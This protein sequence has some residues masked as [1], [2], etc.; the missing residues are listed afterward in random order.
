MDKLKKDN[1]CK[2]CLISTVK[3]NIRSF[4]KGQFAYLQ[5]RGF[6]FTVISNEPTRDGMEL[7]EDTNYISIPITR[8]ITPITDLKSIFKL[9]RIFRREKFDLVQYTTPKG[10]ILGS[11]AAFIAK[12]PIR[13]YLMWGI[14]YVGQNGVKR[15]LFKF[16]DSMACRLSTHIT[17]DGFGIR[18]FAIE[19]QLCTEENSSVVGRGG[20]NGIDLSIFDPEKW[21]EEGNGIRE[22][23]GIPSN[24]VVIGTVMRMVGDKGIN[25]LV[26]AFDKIAANN[27]NVYLLLVGPEE[28]KDPP[29]PETLEKMKNN[30]K[31]KAVGLQTNVLPFYAAMDIFAL[32]TY[33]EGFSAVTLEAQAMELPVVTT[34]AIG[35]GETILDNE[36]G[37]VVPVRKVDELSF[38]LS[39]LVIIKYL[40]TKIGQAGRKYIQENFEQK[41]FWKAILD[42]RLGLLRKSGLFEEIDGKLVRK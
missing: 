7:P 17:F 6:S 42:H 25:E 8:S 28:E 40:R 18:K 13:L 19:E 16:L 5:E 33:R 12:I 9:V 11:I 41:N 26:T 15:E 27:D 39:K 37:F 36:T 29:R 22:S 21:K 20:D 30:P 3:I 2:A 23:L 10:A 14:Y 32:P 24:G 35:A 4:F 1:T 34:D 31:I 38:A